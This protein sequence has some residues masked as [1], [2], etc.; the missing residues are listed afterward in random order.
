MPHPRGGDW[1]WD[2]LLSLKSIGVTDLVSLLPRS[3]EAELRLEAEA[4]ACAELGLRF[5]RHPIFDRG[6]PRQPEFDRFI[7]SLVPLLIGGGFIAIHCRAG[8]GRSS[9]TAAALLCRLGMTPRE[10]L[11]M[12]SSA[13]GIEVP[14]TEEQRAFIFGL[15]P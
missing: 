10:A 4:S 11:A 1:L 7:D 2:E 3:E 13:R 5:H 6:L 8:I 14:D 9:I 12:I 15:S